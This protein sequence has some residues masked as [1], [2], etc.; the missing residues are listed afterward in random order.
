[1]TTLWM[2]EDLEWWSNAPGP[3]DICT[4]TTYW[5][6]PSAMELPPE[7]VTETPAVIERV[8]I[9]GFTERIAH[10]GH[11]FTTM[12]GS[13]DGPTGD[14][15]LTGC[16]VWDHYL[17][18]EYRTTPTGRLRIVEQRGGV[19]QRVT[20]HETIHPGVF[21]IHPDGPV[22][23]QLGDKAEDDHEFCWRASVV[24]LVT[25]APHGGV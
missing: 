15:T 21:S 10:I 16:L 4:P 19:V 12:L 17:W 7:V 25:T 2:L 14:T 13:G 6:T 23:Y 5:A 22:K 20:R 1:M 24:E 8:F 3:G 11:G 9:N 18:A